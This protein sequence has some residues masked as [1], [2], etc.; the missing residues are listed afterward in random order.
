MAEG[1]E[2]VSPLCPHDS[3]D[4]RRCEHVAL[5]VRARL[6]LLQRFRRHAE[7]PGGPCLARG[8]WLFADVDHVCPAF[9]VKMGE[10]V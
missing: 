6:K 10:S 1:D 7:A 4:T 2:L 3:S 8:A 5:A 9:R